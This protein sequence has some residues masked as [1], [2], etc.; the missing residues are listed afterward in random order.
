[1]IAPPPQLL[2]PA[3]AGTYKPQQL[4]AAIAAPD[5]RPVAELQAGAWTATTQLSALFPIAATNSAPSTV[6]FTV[7]SSLKYVSGQHIVYV[8]IARPTPAVDLANLGLGDVAVTLPDGSQAWLT[9]GTPGD[10]PD[11]IRW[12]HDGLIITVA[13]N[14][15]SG[16]LKSLATRVTVRTHP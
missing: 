4:R 8:T 13:G 9:T 15:S 12:L 14:V 3:E 2:P 7:L 1:M 11:Q 16:E 5:S 10:V 6:G